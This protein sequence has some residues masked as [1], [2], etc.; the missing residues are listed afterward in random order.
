MAVSSKLRYLVF[1]RDNYTC[2]YCGASAPDVQLEADH[3]MPRSKGGRDVL[4][5]LVTACQACNGGKSNALPEHW[6]AAEIKAI[7]DEWEEPGEEDDYEVAAYQEALYEL[8]ALTAG[9]V[10]HW[11]AQTYIAAMPYRPTHHE[12]ILCAGGMARDARRKQE[13]G[14]GAS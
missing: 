1:R 3:V 8:A 4:E 6:L 10:L 5:N 9:E 14:N 12:L 11:I 2:R 13:A 7:T